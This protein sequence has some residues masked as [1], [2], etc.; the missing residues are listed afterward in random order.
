MHPAIQS[1]IDYWSS[2][3]GGVM[4]NPPF[5]TSYYCVDEGGKLKIYGVKWN[6]ADLSKGELF[7]PEMAEALLVD[8]Q[9]AIAKG[10][11]IGDVIVYDEQ[12]ARVVD[13][14]VFNSP[15]RQMP[16]WQESFASS[17][18]QEPTLD[19]RSC[20]F[21]VDKRT[22]QVRFVDETEEKV[23]VLVEPKG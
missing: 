10:Y 15:G 8:A 4:E 9:A 12:A 3:L 1:N 19:R 16:R 2:V 21:H 22:H 18:L 14:Y 17:L 23:T 11:A 20:R 5:H 6:G 13:C 7:V